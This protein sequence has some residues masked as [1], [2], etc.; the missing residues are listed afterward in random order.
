MKLNL[1]LIHYIN[2]FEKVTKTKFKDCFPSEERLI[3]VVNPGDCSRAIG[4]NAVNMKKLTS[5]INKKIK[6]VEYNDDPVKFING[7]ISSVK[8]KEI[9]FENGELII[10]A[11]SLKDK[12]LLIGRGGKNIEEVKKIVDHYFKIKKIKIV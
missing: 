7:F 6:V 9:T 11:N 1:D 8:L 12:G 2:L 5:L 4:K 3:F 10:K